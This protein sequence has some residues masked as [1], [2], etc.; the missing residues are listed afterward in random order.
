MA[1]VCPIHLFRQ[2]L[3]SEPDPAGDS[4]SSTIGGSAG[5]D[6]DRSVLCRAI[7]AYGRHL[8][9]DPGQSTFPRV[10]AGLESGEIGVAHD[11]DN[12]KAEC[13]RTVQVENNISIVS[14]HPGLDRHPPH[15]LVVF[16]MVSNTAVHQGYRVPAHTGVRRN[17]QV[18]VYSTR[19]ILCGLAKFYRRTFYC[20]T[21]YSTV[22]VVVCNVLR[23]D[24]PR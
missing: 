9:T 24:A 12:N 14:G 13:G 19:R 21:S 11:N 15:D 22:V 6:P 3:A 4:D 5:A 7:P 20:T 23:R 10:R 8:S 16:P 17:V 2:P 1:L 18:T